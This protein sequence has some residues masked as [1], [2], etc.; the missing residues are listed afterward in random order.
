MKV[1]TLLLDS[2]IVSMEQDA[3]KTRCQVNINHESLTYMRSWMCR[4]LPVFYSVN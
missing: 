2:L 3:V 1:T 4:N